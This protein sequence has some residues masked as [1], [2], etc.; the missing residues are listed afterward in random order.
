M[1][2]NRGAFAPY[3]KTNEFSYP[4][5]DMNPEASAIRI[6][7]FSLAALAITTSSSH[8]QTPPQPVP[9]PA[10]NDIYAGFR[11]TAGGQTRSYLVKLGNYTTLFST[12]GE[13]GS[14]SLNL[15]NLGADLSSEFGSDWFSSASLHWGIFG[16][17]QSENNQLVFGSR[18]RP[19]PSTPATPWPVISD[20][21]GTLRNI[22]SGAIGSVLNGIDGYRGRLSTPNS[23]VAAFQ[24][25]D[26][27]ASSYNFQV[28]SASGD[29][30]GTTD[31]TSIEGNFAPSA[32]KTLD[33]F[34][35]GSTTVLRVGTFTI[36]GSGSITFSKPAATNPNAD[37]DGDGRLD[38]DEVLAGTSPT[39]ASDFFRV[40]S[41]VKT[42]GNAALS[43][44]PAA[45]RTY[46]LEY[47]PDL[48]VGSWIEITATAPVPPTTLP[49]YV[50]T[51]SPPASF[52]FEDTDPVR[53]GTAKGFYRIV[54]SQNVP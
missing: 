25:N 6:A 36:S 9:N 50:T 41:A 1:H 33:L 19:T 12:V 49:R 37:T 26:A 40:Q 29:F 42:S 30:G 3:P 11:S 7:L 27:K 4:D 48:T 38:S 35:T 5:H 24:L 47:S 53:T 14:V 54:V 44:K 45:N 2:L 16:S 39:D 46:K 20:S 8:A 10:P 21:S 28:A 43:F 32:S 51:G 18:E 31:W 34:R 23:L 15:G 17:S 52:A 13:G 22:V